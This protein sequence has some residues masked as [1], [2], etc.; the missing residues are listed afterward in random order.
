[1]IGKI[2]KVEQ[3]K[4]VN[5]MEAML[6]EEPFKVPAEKK[7][8]IIEQLR[9]VTN[10]DRVKDEPHVLAYYRGPAF[11][12]ASKMVGRRLPDIV[13]YPESAKEVQAILQIASNYRV[14]VTTVTLQSTSPGAV[15]YKGGIVLCL[16]GMKRIE[17]VDTD[18]GYAIVEPGV[19]IAQLMKIIRPQGY[20]VGKGSYY[21]TFS[22]VATLAAQS[23]MHNFS[24][25][26]WDQIVGLEIVTPDGSIIY[27]GTMAHTDCEHWTDVQC[28]ISHIKDLF[29]PS[30][31]TTGV[32]TRAAVRIWPLL[33]KTALPVFGFDTFAAAFRWSRAMAKSSMADQVTLWNWVV[34]G[35][36]NYRKTERFLDFMEARMKYNQDDAPRELGLF[37]C[38]GLVQ[39]RGYEE[40][41]RGALR[42]AKR[43]ARQ[44]GGLYLP[45]RELQKKLP[46][47]WRYWSMSWKEFRCEEGDDPSMPHETVDM[48]TQ[49][50]GRTEEIIDVYTGLK[51]KFKEFGYKNW[52]YY[53]RYMNSGQAPWF[54]FF[55]PVEGTT[56]EDLQK[57]ARMRQAIVKYVLDN[58]KVTVHRDDFMF[59]D[60]ENPSDFITRVKP[61]RRLLSAVQK[62]FDPEGI[63]NPVMK[64]FALL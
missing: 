22:V 4:R 23:A 11:N 43:L 55:P 42:T 60:P 35:G 9:K 3:I 58:Y 44:Y 57:T 47:V 49:F 40:E 52:C 48:T 6:K 5:V 39:M 2:E 12:Y 53:T 38:F 27:T 20:A 45:E 64:K 56:Q 37:N 51:K 46:N 31:G 28:S 33:E 25:R 50:M 61:I 13:V 10:S 62:E 14:P 34:T 26:M 24:N 15:P 36:V 54:R 32:I 19:T 8:E 30:S 21:S 41:I 16:M 63:M 17:K 29:I 7:K 1:M 59:N 18:H